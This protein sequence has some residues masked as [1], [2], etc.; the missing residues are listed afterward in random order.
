MLS[1]HFNK[2][3]FINA[4]KANDTVVYATTTLALMVTLL[5][6]GTIKGNLKPEYFAYALIVSVAF[7]MWAIVD[8][9]FRQ[10]SVARQKNSLGRMD[11]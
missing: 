1:I 3:V 4:L 6:Q 7:C 10:L 8:R 11:E 2:Q 9:K 5:F